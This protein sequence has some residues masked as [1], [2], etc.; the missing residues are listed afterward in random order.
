MKRTA[1]DRKIIDVWCTQKKNI[2]KWI[3]RKSSDINDD[4]YA[5][6]H[7]INV[8]ITVQVNGLMAIYDCEHCGQSRWCLYLYFEY[9]SKKTLTFFTFA[10]PIKTN[11]NLHNSNKRGNT[12][13]TNWC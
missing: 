6:M 9:T 1:S 7:A 2:L 4:A 3:K 8:N 13:F 12:N 5:L 10:F 11:E